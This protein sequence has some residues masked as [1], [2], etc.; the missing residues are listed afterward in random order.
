[1]KHFYRSIQGW[2][3]FQQ[4]YVDAVK[5]APRAGARFVEVGSWKGRSAAFMAVEIANSGKVIW[6]DCV[7]PWADGG[8][9]LRHKGVKNLHE[10]FL[11]NI[12]PVQRF[13]K[14]V[15]LPS[16]EAAACY[17]DASLDLVLIDGSHVYEDVAA[18]LHAWARKIKPGGIFA[19]DDYG[20]PGVKR[21]CDEFFKRDVGDGPPGKTVP[22]ACW[23]YRWGAPC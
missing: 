1:M 13:I 14:P 15:R 18:D 12:T 6:F 17:P 8:P 2:S 10:Q 11:R 7:D 20:W 22:R 23:R 9:D 3:A 5:E 19:G 16:V 4:F 21:A